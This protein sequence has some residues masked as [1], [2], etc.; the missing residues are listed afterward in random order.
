MENKLRIILSLFWPAVYSAVL[1]NALY[2]TFA[3][4]LTM[5]FASLII[6]GI[7]CLKSKKYYTWSEYSSL[8]FDNYTFDGKI[9]KAKNIIYNLIKIAI[10]LGVLRLIYLNFSALFNPFGS[11]GISISISVT[12]ILIIL[13]SFSRNF[14]P[15]EK[16]RLYL[17][18]VVGLSIIIF[19]YLVFGTQLIWIPFVLSI[20]FGLLFGG[21]NDIDNK[22]HIVSVIMP[23][24]L[25]LTAITST[26]IQFWNGIGNFFAIIW[27]FIVRVGTFE[28]APALSIWLILLTLTI[29]I[30]MYLLIRGYTRIQNRKAEA[31]KVKKE[32]EEK[33]IKE[34]A[35]RETENTKR[36]D[37]AVKKVEERRAF[38]EKMISTIE[39]DGEDYIK[40]ILAIKEEGAYERFTVQLLT[41]IELK[42]YFTPST[43][44]KQIVWPDSFKNVLE[45]YNT[46]YKRNFVDKDLELIV[47]RLKELSEF[48]SSYSNYNGFDQITK[49]INDTTP[50]IPKILVK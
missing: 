46:I 10:S 37:L 29:L 19:T 3:I 23:I 28:L 25:L 12:L 11:L 45:F 42:N 41:S 44:K 32:K 9:L 27:K 50:D 34:K 20:I 30:G 21:F 15:Y 2:Q 33:A 22:E 18:I 13:L 36:N 43:V 49:I 1:F 5:L 6:L 31:L 39:I 47:T 8:S 7:I 17:G 48:L 14:G 38:I 24:L 4:G 35:E 26:A 40:L 16:L